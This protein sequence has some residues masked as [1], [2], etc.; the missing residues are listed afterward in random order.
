MESESDMGQTC[1]EFKAPIFIFDGRLDFNTPSELVEHWFD[2]IK[3]PVK[4]LHWFEKS[5]HNPMSDEPV[6]FKKL[7]K[8]K[9]LPIAK[10]DQ[11]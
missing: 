1:T 6:A 4:E 11:L 10:G 8:E 5:G 7:L 9:L 2:M 3:A